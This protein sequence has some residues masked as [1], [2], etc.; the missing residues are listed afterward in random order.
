MGYLSGNY[1]GSPHK[2][3]NQ[4]QAQQKAFGIIN[5]VVAEMWA[6]GLT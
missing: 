5:P 4:K 3:H 1:K 6:Y 2:K